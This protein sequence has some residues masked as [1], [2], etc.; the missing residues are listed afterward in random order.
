MLDKHDMPMRM[1][2][3]MKIPHMIP[4]KMSGVI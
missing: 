1:V 2:K 4:V 3:K